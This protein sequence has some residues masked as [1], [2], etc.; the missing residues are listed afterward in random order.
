MSRIYRIGGVTMGSGGG[1]YRSIGNINSLVEQAK[2]ELRESEKQGRRNVFISFA[3]EDIEEVNLLRGQAKNQKLPIEFNDWSVSAPIDSERAAYIKQKISERI[4][5]SSLTIVFLSEN[6]PKSR[7]VNWEI[8]ESLKKGKTVVGVY[9]G[10]MPPNS[11]PKEIVNNKIK[12]VQWSKLSDTIA[13]I[14]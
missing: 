1:G 5:Q 9:A 13:D 12:C 7:W 2:K 6:S 11:Y 10:K 4:S 14:K 8:A 3:Y